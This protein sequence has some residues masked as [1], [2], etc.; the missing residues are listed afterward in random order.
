M[1]LKNHINA[2]KSYSTTKNALN[3][4][5]M[6]YVVTIETRCISA[7]APLLSPP[8]Q[9]YSLCYRLENEILPKKHIKYVNNKYQ[10]SENLD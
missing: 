7:T 8:L 10:T 6:H 2:Y 5:S 3:R 1:N 4:N 9:M